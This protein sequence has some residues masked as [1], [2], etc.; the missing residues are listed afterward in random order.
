MPK[1][2]ISDLHGIF[3]GIWTK[4]SSTEFYIDQVYFCLN[5]RWINVLIM[6]MHVLS[7][8]VRI[9][10]EPVMTFWQYRYFH[11]HQ[12]SIMM[13]FKFCFNFVRYNRCLVEQDVEI[14]GWNAVSSWLNHSNTCYII[15]STT[16]NNIWILFKLILHSA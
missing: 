5:G 12:H 15:I 2:N 7:N 11:S 4:Y 3:K 13:A 8:Q 9:C 6:Y 14:S 16:S 10:Y 1:F